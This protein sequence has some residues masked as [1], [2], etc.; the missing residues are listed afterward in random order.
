MLFNSFEFIF[1]FLPITFLIYFIF[2]KFKWFTAAKVVI[3]AASIFFYAYW[4]Y[5]YVLLLFFS[6]AFN[7]AVGKLLSRKPNK[8]ILIFG[9]AVNLG[10][11]GYYKYVDFFLENVNRLFGTS[12]P[13]L[14]VILPLAISFF[15]FQQIGF[16]VDS[17]RGLTKDY[18]FLNYTLFVVFFPQLI[19]GPIVQHKDVIPQ[20]QQQTVF[21]INYENLALGLFI[22]SSGLFKKVVIADSVALWATPGFD[23]AASLTFFEAWGSAL[24]YTFQLYFDFSGYSEMAIGLGLMFNI[25]LPI[26]FFSPYKANSIIDFWRSWHMTLSAFLKDYLY[27]PLGGNRKG[28][29][30][31]Y[32]NL[33]ITMLLGGIWHGAGW[34]FVIWGALHGLYNVINH[35][36]RDIKKKLFPVKS[37]AVEIAASRSSYF[38]SLFSFTP[39]RILTFVAVVVGWV[40]F[41]AETVNDAVKV[42]KGMAGFNGIEFGKL[43]YFPQGLTE[44]VVLI[45][46]YLWVSF[47]PNTI[48]FSK[49]L[50]PNWKWAML[51]TGLLIAAILF[52]NRKAEFLYFQF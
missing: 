31:K 32:M 8:K 39:A 37:S 12:V 50:K 52:I 3:V 11:L 25:K 24:A 21:N 19:A 28:K 9:I 15:T 34:T 22:F 6:I 20:F 38:F 18:N 42:L 49:R 51:I 29:P 4:D 23:E 30:R 33:F 48:E 26:N 16:L 17:N 45:G 7:F 10:L 47:A 1:V 36:Y 35:L 5:R 13:L 40:F 43:E 14:E 27:I 2:A 41:R 46:L 44:L